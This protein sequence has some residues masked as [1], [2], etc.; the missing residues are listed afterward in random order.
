MS[1]LTSATTRL[2]AGRRRPRPIA[3]LLLRLRVLAHRERLDNELIH[4]TDPVRAPELT[5]RAF[6]LTHIASRRRLADSLDDAVAAAEARPRRHAVSPPLA[7]R[8]IRAA[9]ATLFELSRSLREEPVV[10][11]RG[12][13]LTRRLL[14]DGAGPLY[15]ATPQG[16]LDAAALRALEALHERV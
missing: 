7:R 12:V 2:A 14:T 6:E 3:A 16:T 5:L 1:T 9:R 11:A 8:A 10:A 15:V 13:A 4:G